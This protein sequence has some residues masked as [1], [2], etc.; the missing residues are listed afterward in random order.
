MTEHKNHTIEEL[1]EVVKKK[2]PH[3]NPDSILKTYEFA[4]DAHKDEFRASGE[5]FIIHPLEAAYTI[6]ELGMDEASI[7]A[8]LLHD[9]VE[10]TGK[11]LEEIKQK[12]GEDVAILVDGVTKISEIKPKSKD[13]AEAENIR[14]ILLATCHDI[15]VIIIKLAD[16]L[17]N[18]RTLSSLSPK[19]Q[20][21]IAKET[22]DIYAPIAYRL[23][24]ENMKAELEDLAFKFVYPETY[25]ELSEKIHQ[26]REERESDIDKFK[27]ILEG[28]LEENKINAKIKGRA[29][30]LYSIWKKMMRK[31]RPFEEIYDVLALR[32]VTKSV[33]ECYDSLGIIHQLWKPIPGHIKD[34][35]AMPKA[36]MYQSL[37][38]IVMAEKGWI[39]EIQIRTE[40]MDKIAEEGIA[41]HWAYKG[42][43]HTAQKMGGAASSAAQNEKFDKKISWLRQIQDWQ[44]DEHDA[45]NFV[46]SIRV[47][48]FQDEIYCFT[49]K[50]DV[51]ELPKGATVLD[52]AYAVH[53]GVGDIC[54]GGRVNGTFTSIRHVLRTGDVIEIITAKNQHPT[55]S[56][57]KIAKT[58]KAKNKIRKYIQEKETIPIGHIKEKHVD[59]KENIKTIID[60]EGIKKAKD[61]KLA[62]CCTP[63]PGDPVVG[64]ASRTDIVTVHKI[65]CKN[66][67]RIEPEVK[68]KVKITWQGNV[69]TKMQ[70][71]VEA[72][73][74]VGLFADVLNTISAT[75]TNMDSAR[76]KIIGKE[77]AEITFYAEVDD[78]DH[79]RDLIERIKRIQS[80]KRVYVGRLGM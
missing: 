64:F 23:G 80:V 29:K 16:K 57:L 17:H 20:F 32:V 3:V 74:R 18:M 56:W 24:M 43:T 35:I 75:G 67:G 79:L 1:I 65:D 31:N 28:K 26:K 55:R 51:I 33:K 50:G 52:F 14:K 71:K 78:M 15:R 47:D 77:L 58:S 12:F 72:N 60:I 38:T 62:K 11:K 37:H 69:S 7:S 42:A 8:A 63:L 45:K 22:L 27:K 61:V 10:D 44:K 21:E 53:T 5:P 48:L 39:I 41:A 13:L 68:K 6:A 59:S 54:T 46:D 40:E 34:Y 9:V 2:N 4:A 49:P 25:K 30:H 19:R 66:I 70:L 73:D 36:N 76:A